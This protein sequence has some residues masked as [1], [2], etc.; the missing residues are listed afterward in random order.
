MSVSDSSHN[1]T[2]EQELQAETAFSSYLAYLDSLSST[3]SIEKDV[4][5]CLRALS[6]IDRGSDPTN[7]CFFMDVSR[8]RKANARF[9]T[10]LGASSSR[11]TSQDSR[12]AALSTLFKILRSHVE[13]NDVRIVKWYI[14]IFELDL[15]MVNIIGLELRLEAA[16]LM[17]LL[18]KLDIPEA[19][20]PA[21]ETRFPYPE[22]HIIGSTVATFIQNGIANAP[23]VLIAQTYHSR[24][25]IVEGDC[26]RVLELLDIEARRR[27]PNKV[28]ITSK[29]TTYGTISELFCQR[30]FS[31]YQN[32]LSI[33]L[34]HEPEAFNDRRFFYTATRPLFKLAS[35][36]LQ[37]EYRETL[38]WL[39][40]L[41]TENI[42]ME[43]GSAD[44]SRRRDEIYNITETQR[45]DL[46]RAYEDLDSSQ[47]TLKSYNA[48]NG[49]TDYLSKNTH[50][51]T[52]A[53]VDRTIHHARRLEVEVRDYMQ[54][55]VGA[56]SIA[57]SR[58]SI[59]LSTSQIRES[60]K[61]TP[62]ARK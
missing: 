4:V 9:T 43:R 30:Y 12:K 39:S 57:E 13:A 60:Q 33:L 2:L 52:T 36:E 38:V 58:K 19:R 18:Q 15:Q 10:Q 45:Y 5:N 26:E 1:N 22:H 42:E 23:M 47:Q 28:L 21:R 34:E 11:A 59:E 17:A 3:N 48:I 54:L 20:T 27:S 53:E 46:R 40:T 16:F 61:G 32:N 37:I 29:P 62:S 7:H 31:H 56:L 25:H 51:S 14:D 24:D 55:V 41:R 35:L 49:D 50:N 6:V 8:G 44:K